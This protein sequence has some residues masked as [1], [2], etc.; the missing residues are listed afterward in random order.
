MK[1]GGLDRAQAIQHD[2]YYN[3]KYITS[4]FK[5]GCPDCLMSCHC[6][7]HRFPSQRTLVS[8]VGSR[9]FL[10]A[11]S[12]RSANVTVCCSFA[13]IEN[14]S[15]ND[16]RLGRYRDGLGGGGAGRD[17]GG[18]G[19]Q[20]VEVIACFCGGYCGESRD[21]VDTA[22]PS[23]YKLWQQMNRAIISDLRFSGCHRWTL[24]IRSAIYN[25]TGGHTLCFPFTDLQSDKAETMVGTGVDSDE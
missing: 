8:F 13:V 24:E 21:E 5:F 18:R 17:E 23:K 22:L 3:L 25:H 2:I 11:T 6:N 15:S 9:Q 14:F 16:F 19:I 1:S 20:T 4:D 10:A 12:A 7:D